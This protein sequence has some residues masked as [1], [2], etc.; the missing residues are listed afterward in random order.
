MFT[1]ALARRLEGTG[2]TAN[3]MTSGLITQTELYRNAEPEL[4]KRLTQY[5]GGRT[6]AQGADTA[7]WLASAPELENV[8]GKFFESTKGGNHCA[9]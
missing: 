5:A 9:R 8:N 7:V 3:A 4:V 1:W 6:S 2:V